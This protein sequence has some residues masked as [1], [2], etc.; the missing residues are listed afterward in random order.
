MEKNFPQQEEYQSGVFIKYVLTNA[1]IV[2]RFL[3]CGD[4]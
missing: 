1:G 3:E 2:G 4:E